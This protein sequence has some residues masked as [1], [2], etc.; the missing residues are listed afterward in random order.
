MQKI[1]SIINEYGVL[2]RDG[3]RIVFRREQG[4][5][6]LIEAKELRSD[7]VGCRVMIYGTVVARETV[8]VSRLATRP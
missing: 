4:G 1:G 3:E 6:F 8:Q 7:L 5:R 2:V